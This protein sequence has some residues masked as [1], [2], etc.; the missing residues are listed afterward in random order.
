MEVLNFLLLL[1]GLIC[2]L[3]SAFASH[4]VETRM[5]SV[6]TVALGLAFWVAVPF[7]AAARALG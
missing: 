3:V 4:T 1:G 5:A 6:N 2:F 7:I